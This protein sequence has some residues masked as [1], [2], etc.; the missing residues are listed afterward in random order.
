MDTK[1]LEV[2]IDQLKTSVDILI[3][4]EFCKLQTKRDD[5]REVFG[6]L[7]NNLFAKVN[8]IINPKESS[9]LKTK[10]KK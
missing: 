10:K 9:N 8:K 3:L 4:I 2:K 1:N 7:D 6:T 5:V